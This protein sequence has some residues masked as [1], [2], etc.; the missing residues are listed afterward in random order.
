[1]NGI[2]MLELVSLVQSLLSGPVREICGHFTTFGQETIG[3]WHFNVRVGV[4][5]AKPPVGTSDGD[6]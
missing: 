6:Y 3:E 5:S 2:L 1:M 4:L